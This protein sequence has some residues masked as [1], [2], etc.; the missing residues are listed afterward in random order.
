[1]FVNAFCVR[2]V[3]PSVGEKKIQKKKEKRRALDFS[4]CPVNPRACMAYVTMLTENAVICAHC[5]I[6]SET[7]KKIV[8]FHTSLRFC[9]AVRVT[10]TRNT[11]EVIFS[12]Q[13]IYYRLQ[14]VL[15][16]RGIRYQ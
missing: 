5:F 3:E 1:M 2:P 13:T 11:S 10:G 8:L 7:V 4:V 16:Q 15:S 9:S 6:Y 14:Y 12:R